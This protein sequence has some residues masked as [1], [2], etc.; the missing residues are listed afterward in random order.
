VLLT[1]E[2]GTGKEVIA[3]AIHSLSS[4]RQ[5]SFATLACADRS[6][7]AIRLELLG[8][9][10]P[11]SRL[12]ERSQRGLLRD[13]G[14]GTLYLDEIGALPSALQLE[15][16]AL[17]RAQQDEMSAPKGSPRNDVR[18]IAAS[19]QPLDEAVSRREFS[20][21]LLEQ[22]GALRL[23]LPALRERR[24]D[25]PLLVDHF[26]DH[27]RRELA[28]PVRGIAEDALQLLVAY[29]WPGNI[30]EL[31]NAIEAAVMLAS[32][33]RIGTEDLPP[34][35][36][37]APA[38]DGTPRADLSLKRGRRT[39]EIDIIRRALRATGGNRTHAAR[40]LEI[41]HRA[42]LYKIKEYGIDA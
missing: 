31:K 13:L 26:I 11:R 3:R 17:L 23:E 15:L 20:A 9:P 2:S 5:Q 10:A 16:L 35:I 18:I 33:V 14:S 42:L 40:R 1:G 4:R 34:R 21:E 25:I 8:D 6:A 41:S 32:G 38:A 24:P 28:K 39:C 7:D 37:L 36:A 19:A 12:G 29:P 30:R 22:L 27:F